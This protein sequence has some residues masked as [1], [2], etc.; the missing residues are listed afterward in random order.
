MKLDEYRR[1]YFAD[2]DTEEVVDEKGHKHRRS[3]YRGI[4]YSWCREGFTLPKERLRF[5][6]LELLSLALTLFAGTRRVPL[7]SEKIH[8]GLN[9]LSCVAYLMELR[10]VLGFLISRETMMEIDYKSIRFRLENGALL[11][12]LLLYAGGA[13]GVI[14]LL[15]RGQLDMGS[16]FAFLAY[17]LSGGVSWILSRR[18]RQ[19]GA[20]AY[21]NDNGK[22][23]TPY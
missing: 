8:A 22:V 13:V 10:G 21:H 14:R 1:R 6:L 12:I 2:L 3:V 9:L 20:V 16:L 15:S 4:W 17:L 19:I 5:G 7:N 11:R 23:G 18:L